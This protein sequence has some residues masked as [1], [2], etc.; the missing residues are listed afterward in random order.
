VIF[1]SDE[2][3]A[4]CPDIFEAL[5]AQIGR[6]KPEG[7]DENLARELRRLDILDADGRFAFRVHA[8]GLSDVLPMGPGDWYE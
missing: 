6:T 2:L 4:R 3:A 8:H 7:L 5:R 1:V